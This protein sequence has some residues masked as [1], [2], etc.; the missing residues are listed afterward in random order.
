MRRAKPKRDQA[1]VQIFLKLTPS[2][3]K[4]FEAER[5]R[6]G[7]A[8]RSEFARSIIIAHIGGSVSE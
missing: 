3:L 1:T 6:R 2:D 8:Y 7:I 5:K 4:R